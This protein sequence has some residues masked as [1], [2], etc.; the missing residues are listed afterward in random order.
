MHFNALELVS[1]YTDSNDNDNR[2][3]PQSTTS[4]TFYINFSQ[5]VNHSLTT[6]PQKEENGLMWTILLTFGHKKKPISS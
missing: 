5:M 3:Q 4:F 6:K 2:T 1:S